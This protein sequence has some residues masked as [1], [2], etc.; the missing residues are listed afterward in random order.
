[1]TNIKKLFDNIAK[2]YDKLNDIISLGQQKKI[3]IKAIKN[4][5][6]KPDSKVLDICTGTGD[7]AIY[8]AKNVLKKGTVIGLDFSENML[9]RAK[10]KS[11]N[12]S[13]ISFQIGDALNLPFEDDEFDASFISFG[14][15]NLTDLNQGLLEM[16]R[17][18][19]EGG[20]IINIDTGK[21]EGFFGFL[22]KLYFF[23][24]VPI[25]GKLFHGNETPYKYLP[26]STINFPSGNELVKIFANIGLKDV[27]KF[28]YLF[29]TISQQIGSV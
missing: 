6:I 2:N 28:D 15:R 1:M 5:K 27:K 14:L 10:D 25:M 20:L 19:K 21:P 7:I 12:L 24:I 22:Y 3:K 11:K 17:V 16:K 9:D 13:N 18:T 4:A 8:L 23:K 26:A 29:G